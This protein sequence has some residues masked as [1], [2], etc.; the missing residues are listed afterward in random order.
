M[1]IGEESRPQNVVGLDYYR[2][3][4]RDGGKQSCHEVSPM[5]CTRVILQRVCSREPDTPKTRI[6]PAPPGLHLH[7]MRSHGLAGSNYKLPASFNSD[8][9]QSYL[10]VLTLCPSLSCVLRD[11]CHSLVS[12]ILPKLQLFLAIFGAPRGHS[13]TYILNSSTCRTACLLRRSAQMPAW[14]SHVPGT[15][16]C[17][18]NST[19]YLRGHGAIGLN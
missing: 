8:S 18:S 9:L 17:P 13:Q 2:I 4:L 10:S 11:P 6:L 1:N 15:T 3:R 14:W 7:L 12:L 19:P 16:R 5:Q